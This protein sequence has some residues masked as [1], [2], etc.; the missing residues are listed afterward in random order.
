MKS[1]EA[2]FSEPNYN[3]CIFVLSLNSFTASWP[4]IIG[5]VS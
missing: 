1:D 5:S 3:S 2:D 4:P